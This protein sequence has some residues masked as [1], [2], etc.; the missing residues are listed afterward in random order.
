[1]WI[2]LECNAAQIVIGKPRG[3]PREEAPKPGGSLTDRLVR[4]GG[5]IDIYVVPAEARVPSSSEHLQLKAALRVTRA[6]TSSLPR[7]SAPLLPPVGF[8]LRTTTFPSAW[9]TFWA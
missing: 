6:S 3:S 5:N 9:F 8:C 7:W 4:K 1:M 2:A